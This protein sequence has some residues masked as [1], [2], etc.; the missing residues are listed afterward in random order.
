MVVIL[1]A[2][3]VTE[4]SLYKYSGLTSPLLSLSLL[5]LWVPSGAQT[6]SLGQNAEKTK[7]AF[8]N[9]GATCRTGGN[10]ASPKLLLVQVIVKT[11]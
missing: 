6:T 9:S 5:D 4:N 1:H 2:L 8:C 11:R 7:Q 3:H 10:L